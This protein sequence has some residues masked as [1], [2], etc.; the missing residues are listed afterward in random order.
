MCLSARAI[1]SQREGLSSNIDD[2]WQLIM[3]KNKIKKNR[4]DK[5]KLDW[6]IHFF[7]LDERQNK[8]SRGGRQSLLSSSQLI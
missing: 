5:S 1:H 3:R 7:A 4:F 2:A 8:E 6:L